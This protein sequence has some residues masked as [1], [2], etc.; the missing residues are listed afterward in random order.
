MIVQCPQVSD[1][2]GQ[3]GYGDL[4]SGRWQGQ[5]TLPQ[6]GE[7]LPQRVRWGERRV[8]ANRRS[9]LLTQTD[10]VQFPVLLC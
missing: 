5:E 9:C 4:R 2:L 1:S 3:R 6:R 7:T 10:T 8:V